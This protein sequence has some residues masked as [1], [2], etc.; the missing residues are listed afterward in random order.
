MLIIGPDT[1]IQ[2]ANKAFE[3]ITGLCAQEIIGRK[4]PYPWWVD[5]KQA[6]TH[7]RLN[8][9]MCKGAERVEEV[10]QDKDGKLFWVEVTSTPSI[11]QGNLEYLLSRW[12]DVT[13]RNAQEE[14]RIIRH[15]EE[16][17]LSIQKQE[18]KLA[19]LQDKLKSLGG[20]SLL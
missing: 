19:E 15:A 16:T 14:M 10:F 9:S 13:T 2:Q 4:A 6:E 11:R 12:V 7:R 8:E 20:D 18:K 5:E 17:L 1:L 3:R